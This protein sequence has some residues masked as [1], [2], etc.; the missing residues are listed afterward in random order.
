MEVVKWT[1]CLSSILTIRVRILLKPKVVSIKFVFEKNKNLQK[2][3][4]VGPS[5]KISNHF[6]IFLLFLRSRVLT[7][8]LQK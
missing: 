7:F 2:E 3:T 8:C 6:Y 1:A 4:E 5:K